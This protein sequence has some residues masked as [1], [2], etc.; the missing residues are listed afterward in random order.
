MNAHPIPASLTKHGIRGVSDNLQ[1]GETLAIGRAF[2]DVFR[3]EL[4]ARLLKG[5]KQPC[6]EASNSP[7]RSGK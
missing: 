2:I 5:R 3:P 7:C 6:Q 4:E 1:P